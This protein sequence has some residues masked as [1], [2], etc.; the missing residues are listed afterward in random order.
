M[1]MPTSW[2]EVNFIK[3]VINGEIRWNNQQW[4][5]VLTEVLTALYLQGAVL[6]VQGVPPQVHHARSGGRDP[7]RK[8]QKQQFLSFKD[9]VHTNATDK[10]Y[11]L[12]VWIGWDI[13]YSIMQKLYISKYPNNI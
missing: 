4:I 6:L 7:S 10:K 5:S 8:T 11:R 12:K 3:S 9:I 13:Y 1:G 2:R